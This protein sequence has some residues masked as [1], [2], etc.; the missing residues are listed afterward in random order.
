MTPPTFR[1]LAEYDAW[2]R[3]HG[4][5]HNRLAVADPAEWERIAR[6]IERQ[7]AAIQERT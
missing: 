6:I 7:L 1:T 3:V 4:V 5:E 2:W